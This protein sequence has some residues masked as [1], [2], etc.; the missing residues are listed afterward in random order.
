MI[1]RVLLLRP[2]DDAVSTWVERLPFPFSVSAS[3]TYRPD[4]YAFDYAIGGLPFLAATG[5]QVSAYNIASYV[6]ETAPYRKEQFDASRDVGEQSLVYWWLKSQSSFHGGAGQAYLDTALNS[7]PLQP[8]KFSDSLGVDVWTPGQVTLLRSCTNDIASAAAS[9]RLMGA[10]DGTTPVY[11]LATNATL[12]RSTG[13]ATSSVTWGG[14]GNI[15]S[16][17][18]DGSSY[19]A[20]DATGIYTGTLAGGA[21]ALAWNTGSAN[22]VI[23]WA[24]QRLMAGVGP[25]IYEPPVAHPQPC[26]PRSTHTRTRT[27]SGPLS[28]QGRTRSTQPATPGPPV[29]CTASPST[30][31]EA[32][33]PS[34]PGSPSLRCPRASRSGPCSRTWAACWLSARTRAFGSLRSR[35]DQ[36]TSSTAP[37]CSTPP[38]RCAPSSVTTASCTSGSATAWTATAACTGWT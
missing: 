34:P 17:A 23:A 22:V 9:Q 31:P 14:S 10:Y 1:G 29:R 5:K 20:A 28:L 38:P 25:S 8:A 11:F 30:A 35:A 26:R 12:T 19:Y 3:S 13:A 6:R 36:A 15:L 27:G 24:K 4:G 2:G 21:G 33:P 18:N 7:D 32:C 37:G 16:L